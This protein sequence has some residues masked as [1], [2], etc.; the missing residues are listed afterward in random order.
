M[1]FTREQKLRLMRAYAPVLFLH[2]GEGFVP[3]SPAAYLENSGLWDD[4]LPGSHRR[5]FWGRP[6]VDGGGVL[7][8]PIFPRQPLLRPGQITTDPSQANGDVHFLGEQ[9]DGDFPFTKSDS[10][11]A[12]F[13][14]L[15]HW[16]DT[17][18]TLAGVANQVLETTLNRQAA[19]QLLRNVWGRRPPKL[20][21]SPEFTALDPF[22]RRLS[23]EVHDWI[24]LSWAVSQITYRNF[25]PM[26]SQIKGRIGNPWFIFYHFFYAAHEEALRWCEF[27]A[28]LK[29]L[30]K[31]LPDKPFSFDFDSSPLLGDLVGLETADYAGDWNTVCIIVPGPL[32]PSGGSLDQQLPADDA[33]LPAPNLV[34]FGRRARSIVELGGVYGFDQLMPVTDTFEVL[35]SRHV[36]VY[37]GRGTHNNFA[38]PGRHPSPRSESLLDS[39]CDVNGTDEKSDAPMDDRYR[40]QHIGVSLAKILG[41][42]ALLGPAGFP[43]GGI[44]LAL[45]ALRDR[46]PQPKPSDFDP[47][48]STDEAPG[49]ET[50][51]DIIAPVDLIEDLGLTP[52]SAWKINDA[53]LVDG[54]IWW[55]PPWGPDNGYRG[56]WGV[57]CAEDPF[58]ARSGM[59]FPNTQ[60][61][62][63]EALVVFLEQA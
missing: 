45:E 27:V 23:A 43:L 44:A 38:T 13:L 12:L 52:E 17:L 28:L 24:S 25:V 30:G 35:N 47:D 48:Q 6:L 1:P 14:N 37:V 10:D 61:K 26:V 31:G 62:L 34:G 49:P 3:M 9:I 57:T 59:P 22:K 11:R 21:A 4:S 15:L 55:P 41:A 42:L 63:I 29:T 19:I 51:V 56:A 33:N 5:E 7:P 60:T 16:S 50:P 54:Q 53:D 36:K 46:G 32:M 8:P 18:P 2:G 40:K 58:D 39:A 20:P